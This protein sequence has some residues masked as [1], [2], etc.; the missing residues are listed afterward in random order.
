MMRYFIGI[1]PGVHTGV[2]LW[3]SGLEVFHSVRSMTITGAMSAV[4]GFA[5][6]H[7]RDVTVVFEDA[8][9]RKWIPAMPDIRREMG[10]WQGSGSVMRD[11]KIWEDFCGESGIPFEAVAPQRNRTKLD[12]EAFRSLTGWSQPTNEHGRDAAMLVFGR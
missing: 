7:P 11:C 8:R 12:A 9:K 5:A 6:E 2:A 1:D 10:R 4:G 3:D